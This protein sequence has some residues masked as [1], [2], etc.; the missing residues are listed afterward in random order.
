MINVLAI[1][2]G[3]KLLFWDIPVKEKWPSFSFDLRLLQT[4]YKWHSFTVDS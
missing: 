3:I 4:Q 1:I 2:A